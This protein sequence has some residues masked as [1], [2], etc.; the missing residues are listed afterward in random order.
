MQNDLQAE[1][2]TSVQTFLTYFIVGAVW[3]R[4]FLR[5]IPREGARGKKGL[6]KE[7]PSS[8]EAKICKVTN[9]TEAVFDSTFG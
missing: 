5:A 4:R 1:I 6:L 7:Y 2:G 9:Q 8:L 3:R